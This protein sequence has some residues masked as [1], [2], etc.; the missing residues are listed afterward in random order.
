MVGKK[1]FLSLRY[2]NKT[3]TMKVSRIQN[4]IYKI[5]DSKGTWIAKGGMQ[6]FSGKWTAYD[7]SDA[8]SCS[9]MNNWGIS[10]DTFKQLKK[11]SQQ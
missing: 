5:T 7:C 2:N 9:D 3:K 11:F 1:I 4:G 8:D 10:F 6:T